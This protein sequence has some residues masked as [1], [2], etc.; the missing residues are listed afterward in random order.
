MSKLNYFLKAYLLIK[1]HKNQI[2]AIRDVN[3]NMLN[4]I[5]LFKI[6]KLINAKRFITDR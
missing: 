6:I 1:S 2:L 4:N 3:R 5:F